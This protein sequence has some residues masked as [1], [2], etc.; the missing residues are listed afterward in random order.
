MVSLAWWL[1]VL[2]SFSRNYVEHARLLRERN[3]TFHERRAPVVSA[4]IRP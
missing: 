2:Q 3:V 1:T 4:G